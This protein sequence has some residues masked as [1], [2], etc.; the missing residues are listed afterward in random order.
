[1]RACALALTGSDLVEPVID[2]AN[3]F[4]DALHEADQRLSQEVVAALMVDWRKGGGDGLSDR[5]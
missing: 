2:A 3:A 4:A 5:R 1:M